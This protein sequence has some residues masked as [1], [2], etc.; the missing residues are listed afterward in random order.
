[1][2][3]NFIHSIKSFIK[4]GEYKEKLS[5]LDLIIAAYIIANN[6][7]EYGELDF[8]VGASEFINPLR[9]SVYRYRDIGDILNEVFNKLEKKGIAK[10]MDVKT[11]KNYLTEEE[12]QKIYSSIC[13]REFYKTV[14]LDYNKFCRDVEKFFEHFHNSIICYPTM[15]KKTFE[16]KYLSKY[17]ISVDDISKN[18]KYFLKKGEIKSAA[19]EIKI[20]KELKELINKT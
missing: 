8:A 9:V 18:F 1:M 4:G 19:E 6:F 20:A 16:K 14:A 7:V 2:A 5:D 17:G 12:K 15:D 11:L 13:E 10:C 3:G